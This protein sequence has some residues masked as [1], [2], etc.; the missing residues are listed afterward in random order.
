MMKTFSR[1]RY[2]AGLVLLSALLVSILALSGCNNS[3]SPKPEESGG[4]ILTITIDGGPGARTL[5]PAQTGFQS[6]IVSFTHG[7]LSHANETF[8]PGDTISVPLYTPATPWTV[9][10]TAFTGTGGSGTA[11]A[12]GTA[13]VT[14]DGTAKTA[15]ITLA[16]NTTSGTQGTF[17]YSLSFPT[18]VSSAAL[19]ITTATGG[20]V[21]GGT[22]TADSGNISAGTLNG[23]VS[24]D[25]GY[26]RMNIQLVKDTL[27]AGNTE[28]VHIY[29]GLTTAAAYT[30]TNDD[31]VP[32]LEG[33]VTITGAST[34]N[35]QVG[36]TLTANTDGLTNKAGTPAYTWKRS[37]SDAVIGTNAT[38]Q[39]AAA[40]VSHTITVTASYSGNSGSKTSAATGTVPVP[41]LS[42]VVSITG[43]STSNPQVGDT[44]TAVTTYLEGSTALSYQWKRGNS[45]NGI[46]TDITTTGTGASYTLTAADEGK[47]IRV[48]VNRAG[49]S[50]TTNS[51]VVYV[52]DIII[53]ESNL[54]QMKSLITAAVA[55][56]AGASSANPIEVKVTIA[57]ASLLSGGADPLYKLFDAIP[58]PYRYV[59]YDLSG[60]TFTGIGDTPYNVAYYRT[61]KNYLTAITMPDTLQT[62]GDYAF[63]DCDALTTVSLP[64][65]T[66]IGNSA[67][68]DC[69]A[70]ATVSFPAATTIGNNAFSSCDALTTVSF[71]AATT[72]GNYAFSDCDALTTVSLPAATSIGTEAFLGC[73]AITTM[74]LS[75]VTSIGNRAFYNYR[76]L[77]TVSLPA[78]TSIGT[79]AFLFCTALTT[80]SLP[81]AT[82]IGTE[83]FSHCTALTTVSLP[84]ATSRGTEAFLV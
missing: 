9:T 34:P 55:A 50:G 15:N 80:V 2:T 73:D 21:S 43:G 41:I 65:A 12:K 35:P 14:M 40:D 51:P 30:F 19:T 49:Y 83:A 59:S 22:I 71:P 7:S 77:T 54:N 70:L 69:D 6:Y 20:A 18:T 68:F 17:S 28:V 46:F 61:T 66:L 72:I 13:T 74:N 52:G 75:A 81:A 47:Y 3:L 63:Y 31:L 33:T 16:P 5:Y 48:A 53:T 58:N 1:I 56:G 39:L 36:D 78:A 4:D 29:P 37:G 32:A 64:V 24:L 67:F 62:L 38:Y 76:A 60:C 26:Y 82:S 84:A 8:A 10:V 23:T 44:L 57:N 45:A 25:A 42:G 79:E 11:S 27:G